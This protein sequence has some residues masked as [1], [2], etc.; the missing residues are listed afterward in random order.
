MSSSFTVEAA[1]TVNQMNTA[2]REAVSKIKSNL[3]VYSAS[4]LQAIGTTL[5]GSINQTLGSLGITGESKGSY[6]FDTEVTV[7]PEPFGRN[8][9]VSVLYTSTQYTGHSNGVGL[10]MVT[11]LI[12]QEPMVAGGSIQVRYDVGLERRYWHVECEA[13]RI[14]RRFRAGLTNNAVPCLGRDAGKTGNTDLHPR[15]TTPSVRKIWRTS[16]P[17]QWFVMMCRT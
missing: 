2:T 13:D 12:S 4:S 1:D 14:H 16:Q 9:T 8:F 17:S 7:R 11:K 3:A 10:I 5:T 6:S 15:E